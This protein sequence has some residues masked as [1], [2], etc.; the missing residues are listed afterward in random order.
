M[1][2]APA[3]G[4]ALWLGGGAPHTAQAQ[5]PAWDAAITGSLLQAN[6]SAR[7]RGTALDANGNVFVTGL[8]NGSVRFGNTLLVSS[9]STDLFVAKYV[10]ATNTWAWAVKGG[11]TDIDQGNAIAVSGTSVYV[12]G[13]IRNSLADANNVRFGGTG[14]TAGT[15]V[16]HGASTDA[17]TSD[18]VVAKYTDNGTSA[19]L[20]WTQVGGGSGPD[21]GA[22]VAVSGTSVYVT[23][24]IANSLA[25]GSSVRFGGAGTTPGTVAQHGASVAISSDLV[26][27][28]YTDNGPSA[29]LGWTQVGGGSG[30][31]VG[32]SIAVSGTSVYVTGQIFENLYH[33]RLVRFGGAGTT[34]G[35]VAQHGTNTNALA[36]DLVVAKYTDNG[37]SAT[38]GWTHVGGG[39]GNDLG[40][41]I[42]VNGTSVYVTGTINNSQADGS[43]VR[44]GGSGT[45][46]G[47]VVQA[48]AS[49]SAS[50]DMVVARY[51]DNGPSATVDWTHVGGGSAADLGGAVAVSGT[52]V[53]VTCTIV[54]SPTDSRSVRFGGTGTTPGTTAQN[55]LAS[56]E[57]GDVVVA[58]YTDNGTSATLGWTQIGGGPLSDQAHAIAVQGT[59]MY[60]AG[61]IRPTAEFGTAT[62]SPVRGLST[63]IAF[64]SSISTAGTWQAVATADNGGTTQILSTATNASGHVFVTGNFTGSVLFGNTQLVST[65]SAA[66]MFV[67]KYVPATNTWAWAVQGGGLGVDQGNGIAVSGTSVYITGSITNSATDAS[68][69]RFGGTGATAGTVVLLGTS[70]NAGA[71]LF[72]AKYTDNGTSATLGWTQV[73]GGVGTDQGNGIAVSGTNVY[74]TG[75]IINTL[76]DANSVRFGG[77]GTTPGTVVQ[78]GA[79]VNA[80][81]D[82]VVAKYTDNGTSATLGWTQVGGGFNVD[83]GNAIAVSG[84]SV[85]VTGLITNT[86]TDPNSVRFGGSGTTPGTVVQHGASGANVA[87]LFVA[88][89]T[90]NGP[91]ASVDWTQVGG[92]SNIDQGNAIAVSGAN[93][94]VTGRLHNNLNDGFVVRFGGSGATPGTVAQA[95]ASN[96]GGADLV[97]VKYTDNGPSATLGWTQVGGGNSVDQGNGIAVSGTSVYVTGGFINSLTDANAV[98]FGGAG[99][100]PGTA[101]Q[102]GTSTNST[103]D[104]LLAKYTDNGTSAT[105]NWT[106]LGGGA[107]TDQGNS[108][109]LTGGAV[110]VGATVAPPASFSG[111]P[112][113]APGA[114]SVTAGVLAR[115][116]DGPP[117]VVPTLSTAPATAITATTAT[118]G[119]DVTADGGAPVTARGVVYVAGAGTPVVGAMGVVQVTAGNGTG[120]FTAPATGLSGGT[121]YTVRAY[122]TNAAGTA[123]GTAETFSTAL[124][125]L[126]VNTG[127]AASPV[128][129]AA[130]SYQDI[131]IENG[132]V[133]QLVGAVQVAGTVLVQTGGALLTDC[134]ALTG[135]GSFTLQA[136]GTLGICDVDGISASGN[137]GAVRVS[138][139][140]SF[141]NDAIYHYNNNAFALNQV[142]GNGLPAI[143]RELQISSSLTTLSQPLAVRR[144][145]VLAGLS[146]R[147]A[148]SPQGA[149]GGLMT[150]N[151]KFTL[152]SDA[153]FQAYVVQQPGL[154]VTGTVT[155]QR[156][157]GTPA[158]A[159]YRHLSS[160]VQAAPVGDLT[161]TG[162]TAIVNPAY[163]A[164][165]R[166]VL[167]AASFPSVFGFDEARGGATNTS[168]EAGYFSPATLATVLAPGRGYSVFVPGNRTPD[169]VGALTSGDLALPLGVTGNPATNGKA[170]WHLLGNPYPQPIDW[171]LATL[172]AG[173]DP[174]IYV[175]QSAGGVTGSYRFRN[176]A[177]QTG[178]LLNGELA[179][180]QA[181]FARATA[182]TTFAFADAM[183]V[184]NGTLGISRAASAGA[185]AT[186]PVLRLNLA[187]VGAPATHAD[188]TFL[189]VAPGATT[190]LD[191]GLDAP[192]PGRN[193][194]VPTL[195]SL[196]GASEAAIN[197]LPAAVLTGAAAETLVE[198]TAVLPATGAYTLAV[199]ELRG[200]GATSVALLDRLTNTRYDLAQHPTLTLTAARAN[201]EVAGRFAVVLHGSQRVLGV[202]PEVP[203]RALTVWPNPA[204]SAVQ[205]VQV[206]GGLAGA[207]VALFDVAGRRV[208]TAPADATGTATLPT[209]GLA[210]GVYVVRAPDGRTVRLVVE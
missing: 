130:G 170:G 129:V 147:P 38:L 23:G 192:R 196:I 157:V 65:N 82:I 55:G 197:A 94:Y 106:Q 187:Q 136:G 164:L 177:T 92:G 52:S 89:Y 152:L 178:T 186:P 27:A 113:V 145:L 140:R 168:F 149:G 120:A 105:F 2:A 162:F 116:Q 125:S 100:T 158:T 83:Q 1:V 69:V 111:L 42:A 6:G 47:T 87:D 182:P 210:A 62:G 200:W 124:L 143:V 16:Q 195:A 184:E 76:S 58:N 93:V 141:S 15:A 31:D 49:A 36:S 5:V 44:F 37:P 56:P 12:A 11:G 128:P 33:R 123:Y 174:T 50:D 66:D 150:N 122:A 188:A 118:L 40:T 205:S 167:S 96:S 81:N 181:F 4:L 79:S 179:L 74:V 97:V 199:G 163:N 183:R 18:L 7:T 91:S 208:A 138:G 73:G 9:G 191:A 3:L 189:T 24:T 53:Y 8:F 34:P 46:P 146:G 71:D 54:N 207:A 166:P 41:G 59:E 102:L 115:L 154:F 202:A 126:V 112:V 75:L 175:W 72:V 173:L 201:E 99:T 139:A 10:P 132:G 61:M 155:V 84:T 17:L 21:F 19:T 35:T 88:K 135:A 194:G 148:R 204:A 64:V 109:A 165:P 70:A 133:A 90:D 78:H 101:V 131:T 77:S 144:R 22:G 121:T 80:A 30:A 26:V 206:A 160:P 142:T 60:V 25:D 20:G 161:T 63:T 14:A 114:G 127:T 13:Q 67:A 198:L 169:F 98:R 51:T 108:L 85:Y 57:A 104:V 137:T 151:Q 172:P 86:L 153:Q 119:G 43:S 107:S 193:V 48:G 180:G 117:A 29:T 185:S 45:T 28:K 134:Q 190:G 203:A 110:Y 159:S 176:A 103:F 32:N 39:A 171:D 209:H 156:F 95:G 68:S